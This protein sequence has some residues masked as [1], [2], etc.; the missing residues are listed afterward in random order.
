MNKWPT[1]PRQETYL[2]TFSYI[3]LRNEDGMLSVAIDYSER[4]GGYK[5]GPFL[6]DDLNYTEVK[7]LVYVL[8][9]WLEEHPQNE[10]RSDVE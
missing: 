5:D 2:G 4:N 7:D 1:M 6:A 3:A 10:N 8:S 9:K